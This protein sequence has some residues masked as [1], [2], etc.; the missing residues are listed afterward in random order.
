MIS[1][2]AATMV[3]LYM[4]EVLAY[5]AILFQLHK[6][7]RRRLRE[8]QC[9]LHHWKTASPSGMVCSVCHMRVAQ[10][11]FGFPNFKIFDRDWPLF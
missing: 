3:L 5:G 6:L 10:S 8:I 1:L 2:D 11:M 9:G 7:D 4:V